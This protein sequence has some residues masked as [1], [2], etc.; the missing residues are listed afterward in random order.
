MC[1]SGALPSGSMRVMHLFRRWNPFRRTYLAI[2]PTTRSE[3]VL[4][5]TVSEDADLTIFIHDG[6]QTCFG[7]ISTWRT[8]RSSPSAP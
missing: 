5:A 4:R 1:R 3:H 6:G 7:S 8:R 2:Q